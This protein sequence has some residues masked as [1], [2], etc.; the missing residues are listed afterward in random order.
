MLSG[1]RVSEWVLLTIQWE[2]HMKTASQVVPHSFLSMLED[3]L[4]MLLWYMEHIQK[5]Y[6]VKKKPLTL[7]YGFT[8]F[9]VFTL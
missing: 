2:F 3:V 9:S 7:R 6:S 1:Q 8:V 4:T 5:T